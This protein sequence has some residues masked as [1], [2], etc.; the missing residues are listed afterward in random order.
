MTEFY[1]KEYPPFKTY[2]GLIPKILA[3]LDGH[4]DDLASI[5]GVILETSN[6]IDLDFDNRICKRY[7]EY[8]ELNNAVQSF[9]NFYLILA[10]QH[11]TLTPDQMAMKHR[12]ISKTFTH[13][14]NFL[15]TQK[16]E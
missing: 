6:K 1:I 16:L 4:S 15:S 5:V 10:P 13:L 12:A 7:Y 3:I 9:L 11:E 8:Q 2:S 14:R